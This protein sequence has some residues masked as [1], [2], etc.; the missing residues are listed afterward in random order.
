M[1]LGGHSLVAVR[2]TTVWKWVLVTP[3]CLVLGLW[4]IT[5]PLFASPDEPAN[6]VKSAAIIRGE[7]VGDAV[8]PELLKSYWTTTVDIDPQFGSVNGLPWCFAPY[9]EKP[10]CT[11]DV[12]TAP[13]VDGVAWTNMGKYPP[14]GFVLTGIGTIFGATN[15]SVYASRVV[16]VVACMVLLAGSAIILLRRGRSLSGLLVALTPGTIFLA[17]TSSPS[18][19][20][21]VASIATWIAAPLVLSDSATRIERTLFLFGGV[22]LIGARPLGVVFYVTILVLTLFLGRVSLRTAAR[23]IGA[24]TVAVHGVTVLF[25]LWWYFAIYGPATDNKIA[26]GDVPLTFSQQF[27]AI[28]RGLPR[29]FEQYIGNF[30]WLDTPAPQSVV[31]LG[32]VSLGALGIAAGRSVSLRQWFVVGLLL[33]ASAAFTIVADFNYYELLRTFGSQGRHV[34]PFLVGIPIVLG[35]GIRRGSKLLIPVGAAWAISMVWSFVVMIRRYSVGVVPGNFTQMWSDPPWAP[36]LG[37]STTFAAM[38]IVVV[39]GLWLLRH[40]ESRIK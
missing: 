33:S 24:R 18:G 20:E 4:T 38:A 6:F 12:S 29:I 22:L 23:R 8:A 37:V 17:S 5:V 11:Y 34:A 32:V 3:L 40:E 21:I 28:M 2:R 15:L 25:M 31:W 39:G 9:P 10:A 7:F 14:L 27:D 1:S 16:Q 19:L 35:A 26:F 13:Q 30:G 36:P